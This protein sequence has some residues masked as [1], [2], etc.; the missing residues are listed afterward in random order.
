MRQKLINVNA[1]IHLPAASELKNRELPD[2]RRRRLKKNYCTENLY[3]SKKSF[4]F[5][6]N[7]GIGSLTGQS[8]TVLF[9]KGCR[10]TLLS[11]HN[12]K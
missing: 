6:F 8:K 4:N 1:K 7:Q 3:I 12:R 5:V 10:A 2:R 11:P 9:A